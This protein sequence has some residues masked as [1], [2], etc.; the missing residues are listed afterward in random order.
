MSRAIAMF[1]QALKLQDNFVSSR[2]HLGLMFHKTNQFQSAL[3]C[4]SLVLVQIPS[5]KTV[6]IARGTV[7]QD[8]GNHQLAIADFNK[9]IE[10]DPE[11]SEG[12]FR[13]G[14]SK[15]NSKQYHEAIKD[16]EKSAQTESIDDD[17]RNA[18]IPDGLGCCYHALKEMDKA[19]EYYNDA[20]QGNDE[21]T[22]FLMHRA[23]C[24]YDL[25]EYDK[26]KED[27][28]LALG[29]AKDDPQIHYRLGLS[30]YA[31]GDYKACVKS[32]K[33]A[34]LNKPFFS[35][36]ADIYYHIGLAYCNVE[37]F[38]KAIYPFSKCIELNPS[39]ITFLHERAKA[40]QMIEDHEKAVADFDLLI[41]KNPKNA[42][43]HFRRAFS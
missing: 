30:E 32:L 40:Y 34:L 1:Q 4:H 16:F 37:K 41:K 10:L 38:E 28:D 35:Y 26:A 42:H 19:L 36:E 15:L 33:T 7:Y 13:R 43:A 22:E 9:S 5:D 18:G 11:L 39:E 17:K 27:L 23:Q 2:F 20:V 8:M 31:D 25:G 14:I 21:N 29:I 3:K 6:Y 24:Y 12:Y